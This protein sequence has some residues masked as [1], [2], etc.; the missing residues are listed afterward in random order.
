MVKTNFEEMVCKE[1]K[2]VAKNLQLK[3][4]DKEIKKL[5]KNRTKGKSTAWGFVGKHAQQTTFPNW[6]CIHAL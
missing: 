6:S 5:A 3:G 1:S 2:I 4:G